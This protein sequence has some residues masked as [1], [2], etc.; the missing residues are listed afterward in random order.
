MRH[1]L[2]ILALLSAL[3]ALAA[4]EEEPELALSNM[5]VGTQADGFGGERPVVSGDI[6]NYGSQAYANI[7]ILVEAYDAGGELIGEGFGFLVDACGTALLDY[8][9][10]PEGLQAFSA[11]FELFEDGEAASVEVRLKADALDYKP[12]P[13]ARSPE[14]RLIARAE[15][16]QLQWLDEETLL[17]GVGC[18]GAV[19]TELEW[20][21]YSLPDH[22]LSLT[23]HPAAGH[24]NAGMIERSGAAMITQSGDQNP[25]LF[26]G[27]QMTFPPK[28]RRIVYQNDLHT[29]LSAEP[30]G[31]FKRLIHD[32]LHKHS[33]R[34]FIWAGKPGVFLAYYFGA[35][36]EPVHY[37]SGDVEG[38]MLMG[39]LEELE[40]SLTVP[41]PAA[42][43][44]SAVVGWRIDDR[45]G[46]YQR[47]A[48]G[49]RELLFEADLPGNNYPAPIV[50][51][52]G[53]RRLIYVIRD[54]EGVPSL[55]CFD[56]GTQELRTLTSLP[57]RLTR[58]SR[59]WSALSPDGRVL[60]LAANGTDGGVWR[61]DVAGGCG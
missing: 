23:E 49:S 11:P 29:I 50:A 44:L 34:G 27:S 59:A 15:A 46:Y 61:V 45:E 5:R 42:D 6:H 43:G 60:A 33:L 57:L 26:Y 53:E 16:V 20:W 7:N 54:V 48:Y 41:G 55:Q 51:R 36:G 25:D 9:L 30:D 24:I 39:R 56:R 38:R 14:A 4:A 31:S 28:A 10:P 35:Y 12:E 37:F 40:P 32:G 52:D 8:A 47:Y 2:V 22:A 13:L 3:A 19:F 1:L 17:Y 58:E 21:R 18:A